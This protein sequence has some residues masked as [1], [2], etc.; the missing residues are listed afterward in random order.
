MGTMLRS[1]S[2]ALAKPINFLDGHHSAFIVWERSH[3][4]F[5]G[6]PLAF[7]LLNPDEID[8]PFNL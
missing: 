8:Y 1:G 5:I 2:L 7:S 6:F 3:C 4:A